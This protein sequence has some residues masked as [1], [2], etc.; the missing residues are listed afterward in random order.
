MKTLIAW[1]IEKLVTRNDSKPFY[2]ACC[3]SATVRSC[4]IPYIS[5]FFAVHNIP[6]GKKES[7][8]ERI[9]LHFY[10]CNEV[11]NSWMLTKQGEKKADI[12]EMIFPTVLHHADSLDCKTRI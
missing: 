11:R 10:T 12:V 1:N 7:S 2:E 3:S 9:P 6:A 4:V 8:C 5:L